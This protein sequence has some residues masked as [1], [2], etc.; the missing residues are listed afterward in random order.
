MESDI[1]EKRAAAKGGST[2][3]NVALSRRSGPRQKAW[4]ARNQAVREA[5]WLKG[6]EW[7]AFFLG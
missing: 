6:T 7:G 2:R 5:K 4:E 1:R 3:P